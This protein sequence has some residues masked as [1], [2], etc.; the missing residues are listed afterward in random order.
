MYTFPPH[1]LA[2]IQKF[3]PE[4]LPEI[5][6]Y[7]LNY[8]EV[9][10]MLGIGRETLRTYTVHGAQGLRIASRK[11]GNNRFAYRLSDVQDFARVMDMPIDYSVLHASL[12][13]EWHVG[14]LGW[15]GA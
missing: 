4:R 6:E 11:F 12:Q 14:P 7:R 1:Y 15:N 8:R 9:C 13:K 3:A 2:S 5:L 10:P